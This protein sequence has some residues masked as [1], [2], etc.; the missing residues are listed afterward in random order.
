MNPLLKIDESLGPSVA[1]PEGKPCFTE[2]Y[3]SQRQFSNGKVLLLKVHLPIMTGD[4]CVEKC[5]ASS[6][7]WLAKSAPE[8]TDKI[9]LVTCNEFK[10]NYTTVELQWLEHL[11]DHRKLFET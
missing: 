7:P 11:W 10:T 9:L 5:A 6:L 8:F 2:A 1:N 4:P 3:A